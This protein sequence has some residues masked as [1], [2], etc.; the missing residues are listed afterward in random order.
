[1]EVQGSVRLEIRPIKCPLGRITCIDCKYLADTYLEQDLE[2]GGLKATIQ[3]NFD[4][5]Q[6]IGK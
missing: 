4:K 3:C 5:R 2:K 6:I 1:M